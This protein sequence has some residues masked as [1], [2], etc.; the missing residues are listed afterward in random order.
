MRK[1]FQERPDDP[2]LDPRIPFR[3]GRKAALRPASH[4]VPQGGREGLRTG[5]RGGQARRARP[6]PPADGRLALCARTQRQGRQGRV[7]RP[8]HAVLDRQ[9][10]SPRARGVGSGRSRG[11][12]GE[13]SRPFRQGATFPVDRP[14]PPPLPLGARRRPDRL[15]PAA[16]DRRPAR[17]QGPRRGARRRTLHEA[18]LPDGEGGRRSDRDLLRRARNRAQPAFALRLA[19]ARPVAAGAGWP[20]DR[21]RTARARP[22]GQVRRAAD[23][24]PAAV[25][26]LAGSGYR[27]PPARAPRDDA[28]PAAGRRAARGCRGEPAVPRH[29]DVAKEPR[30]DPAAAQ[31]GGRVRALHPRFRPGRGPDAARHVSRLH[32]RRA[33]D[34]GDRDPERDRGRGVRRGDAD[35]DRG[36]ADGAVA[37]GALHGGSAARHRQGAGRRSF[38][39]RRAGRAAALSPGRAHAGGPRP[40]WCVSIW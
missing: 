6:T 23:R 13:R 11:A 5:L 38:R 36:G 14:L 7:A 29:A 1:A 4:A 2:H 3:L 27:H 16:R 26:Y 24:H 21:K 18:L 12:A 10:P 8:A 28:Q 19:E 20:G 39:D 9:I 17:L 35:R 34:H 32:G 30:T 22:R 25:P 31:R 15:R 37:P 33:H 40:G